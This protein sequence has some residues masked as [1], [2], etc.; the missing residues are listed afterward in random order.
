MDARWYYIVVPRFRNGDTSNDPQGTIPW[1]A[2][3]PTQGEDS[4]ADW[5]RQAKEFD[6]RR[7][8]GDLR[9]VIDRLPYLKQLG[10]NAIC[11][12]PV[13]EGTV[14]G[15]S[16]NADVR[17]VDALVGVKGSFSETNDEGSDPA[18]WKWSSSDKVL[19]ELVKTAHEQG[20]RVVLGGMLGAVG[21]AASPVTEQG[22]YLLAAMK[23]WMDPNA[24]G[25]PSDGVDGWIHAFE[26]M[27]LAL[28][29]GKDRAFRRKV[30]ES[31]R[32]T[33]PNAV[34]IATG[35]FATSQVAD[36]MYDLF[37]DPS[38]TAAFHHFFHPEAPNASV[39]AFL[40]ELERAL[41]PTKPGAM[42]TM[43]S[44]VDSPRLL[45]RFSQPLP[46]GKAREPSAPGPPPTPKAIERWRLAT[47]VAHLAG[48]APVTFYGDEAGMYGGMGAYAR[49][50]MWW[51]DLGEQAK[52]PVRDDFRMLVEWLHRV[53]EKYPALR[54]GAFRPVMHDDARKIFA[55]ART[56]PGDEAIVAVN[57]GDAKQEFE[58]TLGRPG[59]MV[60]LMSP[61]IQP[62]PPDEKR[63]RPP[64]DRLQVGGSRQFV[65]PQGR[66]SF[67]V[68]PQS[69]RI[70]LVRDDQ[71]G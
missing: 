44:A 6:E 49:A 48:G 31:V 35:P 59:Q 61:Q 24:D 45:T 60:A 66:I 54:G 22:D 37:I 5:S 26:E 15:R 47:V 52:A 21:D 9:G 20:L 67:W 10:V 39:K 8:G 43:L 53:R 33:N 14:E 58:I 71:G 12:S 16:P 30:F 55:F 25:D 38:V 69:A 13:F 17:H 41:G 65:N 32:R 62:G 50:P 46:E 63:R 56:L 51:K 36:G 42:L 29:T 40:S 18:T 3:W 57:Y 2:E 23:R 1:S 68:G 27:E 70:V 4:V 7:Y 34:M 28:P 19:L 64:S 11:L